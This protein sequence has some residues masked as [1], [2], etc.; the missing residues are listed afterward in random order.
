MI[1]L[2]LPFA[3]FLIPAPWIVW[4]L[5]PP[6]RQS[7]TS[8]RF[9]FFRKIVTA[10]G[11][12]ARSGSLVVAR[13]KLQMVTAIAVW[14]LLVL[15]LA[16]PEQVGEPVEVT[17]AARDLILA[18][19][20]S[21][22][23]DERDFQSST[24]EPVQRLAAVK[25]II[26]EFVEARDGDRVALIVF[27]SRAFVQAPFTED[28]RTVRD[29]LEQTEVG[30]AGPHTA[31]G[32]AIGLAIRT[33][34]ASEI[35]QRLLVLLSDGADTGSRMSPINA[36]EIASQN[37]VEIHTIGVGR[38]DGT[39]ELRVDTEALTDIARRGG[40]QFFFANDTE[41]L[42]AVYAR[43]DELTPRLVETLS[44]RPRTALGHWPLGAGA[45]LVLL[46][47]IWLLLGT[48]RGARI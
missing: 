1:E 41:G 18:I 10:T 11:A 29:L 16:Q 42:A 32:D 28:L 39:G 25:Q 27:G 46:C 12:D 40:G 26:G 5:M 3:L 31:I 20:I 9:P 17:K 13:R 38:P 34:E 35:D 23:M 6:H 44:F 22:S 30:M 2:A 15:A 48:R 45:L 33:F 36:A 21:G 4:R 43:V 37:G 8:L 19:D 47:E 24:G 7:T 14:G